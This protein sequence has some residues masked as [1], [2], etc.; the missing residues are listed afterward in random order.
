ML[1]D[2][3]YPTSQSLEDPQRV[4]K[5]HANPVLVEALKKLSLEG[6]LKFNR[7]VEVKN[8]ARHLKSINHAMGNASRPG[9]PT[10]S[11]IT[12]DSEEIDLIRKE[13]AFL[14]RVFDYL[15]PWAIKFIQDRNSSDKRKAEEDTEARDA[16]TKRARLVPDV[17]EGSND[18]T[19]LSEINFPQILFDTA[20]RVSG[21]IP[22]SFF[23]YERLSAIASDTLLTQKIRV[24]FL[25][26]DG[27]KSTV[28]ALDVPK[29]IEEWKLPKSGDKKEG[30]SFSEYREA[31]GFLLKFEAERTIGG[32]DSNN[33]KWL[34][35]HFSF[36]LIHRS[37][38]SL[39]EFW[40]DLEFDQRMERKI[41]P[42]PFVPS[43][44]ENAW[45]KAES[46]KSRSIE[47]KEILAAATAAAMSAVSSTTPSSSSYAP[48]QRPMKKPTKFGAIPT[49]F[50]AGSKGKTLAPCCLGCGKRGHRIDEHIDSAHGKLLWVTL[51][52]AVACSPD[53]SN[54]PLCFTWNI[55]RECKGC[56]NLHACSFCGRSD[57]HAFSWTCRKSPAP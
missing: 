38:E 11:F 46:N 3:F 39:F 6:R 27:K 47:V 55:R 45:S 30:L 54:K 15:G 2:R 10:A 17:E 18:P 26:D 36:W 5:T 50:Q 21:G 57:H 31:A 44:Y 56:E 41:Y 52:N 43:S 53:R 33:Y 34:D 4:H 23:T 28:Y 20:R 25:D 51:V 42:K 1:R 8:E 48:S 12:V 16:A 49:P 29:L 14:K 40:K 32:E 9:S 24:S 35:N 19:V 37:S 13:P 22:L 7:E